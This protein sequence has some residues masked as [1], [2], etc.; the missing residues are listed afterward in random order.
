MPRKEMISAYRHGLTVSATIYCRATS[1]SIAMP[2][3]LLITHREVEGFECTSPADNF[4][5]DDLI[6]DAAHE[7]VFDR[8]PAQKAQEVSLGDAFEASQCVNTS[9]CGPRAR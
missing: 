7:D 3:R 1:R 9:R 5:R 8:L 4:N 6:S 2:S